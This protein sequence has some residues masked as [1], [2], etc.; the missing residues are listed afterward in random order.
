MKKKVSRPLYGR[1]G[2][3]TLPYKADFVAFDEIYERSDEAREIGQLA[4]LL[5]ERAARTNDATDA[6]LAT[7]VSAMWNIECSRVSERIF[8]ERGV[9]YTKE[10]RAKDVAGLRRACEAFISD[11]FLA[12]VGLQTG[13]PTAR[14]KPL[15]DEVE[16]TLD[17]LWSDEVDAA[18]AAR[19]LIGCVDMLGLRVGH[20][21]TEKR[22]KLERRLEK[23]RH[24][25]WQ[26]RERPPSEV[27]A[28]WVLIAAGHPEK[29]AERIA[30]P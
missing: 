8:I 7:M 9:S 4:S 30:G 16:R 3:A 1:A 11:D 19:L 26:A 28:K 20:T 17:A 27:V 14:R 22:S 18:K 24:Q 21:S 2:K 13:A 29:Q 10:P 6:T 23:A 15:L 5:R 25:G 12:R